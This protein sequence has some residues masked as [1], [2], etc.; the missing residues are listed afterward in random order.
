MPEELL[1]QVDE[2]KD[3]S[4]DMQELQNFSRTQENIQNLKNELNSDKEQSDLILSLE[5]TLNVAID[6]IL[7]Q[8]DISENDIKIL[9]LWNMLLG[10]SNGEKKEQV[11]QKIENLIKN[12]S[13]RSNKNIVKN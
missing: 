8:S 11:K 13:E 3:Q 6:T 9:E 12:M 5:T 10:E 1:Q 2:N 7:S 4:I